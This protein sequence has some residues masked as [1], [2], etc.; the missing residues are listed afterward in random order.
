M[1]KVLELLKKHIKLVLL[2]VLMLIIAFKNNKSIDEEITYR[3]NIKQESTFVRL[4]SR[5]ESKR[6]K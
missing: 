4:W 1:K 6:G 3:L 2:I 5:K